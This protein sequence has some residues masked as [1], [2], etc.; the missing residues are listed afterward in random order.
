MN[1]TMVRA[2][3]IELIKSVVKDNSGAMLPLAVDTYIELV[4][5]LSEEDFHEI[6]NSLISPAFDLVQMC[7]MMVAVKLHS[8]A[9]R[10]P[11]YADLCERVKYKLMNIEHS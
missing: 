4:D 11:I 7:E 10:D 5:L 1:S 2:R 8:E 3:I 9:F 6:I